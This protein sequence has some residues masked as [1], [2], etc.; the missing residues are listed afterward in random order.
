MAHP[1]VLSSFRAFLG[2]LEG[3][4]PFFYL[5][6]EG[7]VTAGDGLLADP[8]TLASGWR[9]VDKSTGSPATT[10]AVVEDWHNVKNAKHLIPYGWKAFARITRCE[11]PEDEMSR[12]FL[13]KMAA[14][15]VFLRGRWKL[16]DTW[17][18]D[19]QIAVH[20]MAWNLGAGFWHEF[21]RFAALCDVKDFAG[22]AHECTIVTPGSSARNAADALCLRNAAVVLTKGLVVETLYWPTDLSA[23]MPIA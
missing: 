6:S 14:N 20:S 9:F 2:P 12:L 15:E 13:A 5:D 8:L 3:R 21:P 19:A 18:A 17:P 23:P 16:W 10:E 7:Y 4:V 1:S 11:L 22:A